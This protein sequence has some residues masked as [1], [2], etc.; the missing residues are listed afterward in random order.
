MNISLSRPETLMR[1]RNMLPR[2][3]L[4]AVQN[5]TRAI[6]LVAHLPRGK[7]LSKKW[8]RLLISWGYFVI[9]RLFHD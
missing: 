9:E 8:T 3:D 6:N 1:A 7:A 2:T 5:L 4:R